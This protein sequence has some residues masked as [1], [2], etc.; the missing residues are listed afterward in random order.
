M[1]PPGAA[2]F[3][4]VDGLVS[5]RRQLAAARTRGESFEV[6]WSA[7]LTE[8]E[9]RVTSP[10][11]GIQSEAGC[12]LAALRE[13]EASWEAAY[14]GAPD[15]AMRPVTCPPDDPGPMPFHRVIS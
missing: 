13:T 1:N 11:G 4:A 5:T 8:V 3:V 7:A 10:H 15:P 6:A 2:T 9:A 12:E 14:I